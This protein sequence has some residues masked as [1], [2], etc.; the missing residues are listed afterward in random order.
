MRRTTAAALAGAAAGIVMSMAMMMYMAA[1]GRSIW[2]MPNLIAAMWLGRGA[3]GETLSYATAVGFLT[4]LATSVAM[5]VVAVSFIRDLPPWR[6]ILAG[7]TY[8]VASYPVIFA[9]VLTWANP[10]MVQRAGLVPM[11]AG[12]ALFGVVMGATY[13]WLRRLNVTRRRLSLL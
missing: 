11:T 10:L 4:H 9:F 1:T 7:F 13:V 2:A 5:G 12:H 6:T 8:A 3:A